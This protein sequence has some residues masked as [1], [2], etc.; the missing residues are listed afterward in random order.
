MQGWRYGVLISGL[1]IWTTSFAAADPQRLV[2]PQVD[3]RVLIADIAEDQVLVE[4]PYL[5]H[6]GQYGADVDRLAEWACRLY[7]RTAVSLSLSVSNRACDEVGEL[8]AKRDP[9]CWHT[10][11]YACAIP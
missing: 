8:G 2:H 9:L 4:A 10:H 3:E 1:L 7:K 6:R 5:F 11:R